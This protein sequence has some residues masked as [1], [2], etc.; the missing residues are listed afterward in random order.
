MRDFNWEQ[1]LWAVIKNDGS[2]AGVPCTGYDEACD[3]AARR[4]IIKRGNLTRPRLGGFRRHVAYMQI[5]QG[6][7][8]FFW[9]SHFFPEFKPTRHP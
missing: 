3:L 2:F 5:F 1:T 8:R 9:T 6:L 7:C 4:V